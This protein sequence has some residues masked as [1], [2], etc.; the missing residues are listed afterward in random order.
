MAHHQGLI[1]L[2]VNNL[3]NNKILPERFIENPEIKAVSI[4]LQ[5]TMPEMSIVTKEKKE[6]IEKLKYRL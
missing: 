6:K 4:L 3:I 2:S 1:L 5:E